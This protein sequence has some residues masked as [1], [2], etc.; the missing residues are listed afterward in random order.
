MKN[1]PKVTTL[2]VLDSKKQRN[3]IQIIIHRTMFDMT[4]TRNYSLKR[5]LI[6]RYRGLY[7]SMYERGHPD[8]A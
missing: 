3:C 6:A 2:S 1:W 8:I 5:N 7:Q 4:E